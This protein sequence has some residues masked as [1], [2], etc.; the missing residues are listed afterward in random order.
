MSPPTSVA[1]GINVAHFRKSKGG[2]SK[3]SGT[4]PAGCVCFDIHQLSPV[5]GTVTVSLLG[6]AVGP[7]GG[8]SLCRGCKM[9]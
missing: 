7:V 4:Q 1:I 6:S 5:A 9:W 8:E 3:S 2:D